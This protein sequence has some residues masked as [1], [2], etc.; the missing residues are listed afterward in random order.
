MRRGLCCLISLAVVGR[1]LCLAGSCGAMPESAAAH[2]RSLSCGCSKPQLAMLGWAPTPRLCSHKGPLCP[3]EWGRLKH[4][5]GRDARA[6]LLG[7]LVGQLGMGCGPGPLL[8]LGNG[9]EQLV[10]EGEPPGRAGSSG[11]RETGPNEVQEMPGCWGT[12]AVVLCV[13]GR[14]WPTQHRST[15]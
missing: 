4:S 5:Q 1:L 15:G 2:P 10:E 6:Q 3:R 13:H 7:Q 8:C 12:G 9:H 14:C 11:L